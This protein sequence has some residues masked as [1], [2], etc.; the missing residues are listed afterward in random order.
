M[1]CSRPI[2]SSLPRDTF[3]PGSPCG[4]IFPRGGYLHLSYPGPGPEPHP[5][6]FFQGEGGFSSFLVSRDAGGQSY[7]WLGKEQG[8]LRA[9]IGFWRLWPN[10]P[11]LRVLTWSP[12][13]SSMAAPLPWQTAKMPISVCSDDPTGHWWIV[14]D[15]SLSHTHTH[16]TPQKAR[17]K[18][19][20]A[21][22]LT[23][24]SSST[25]LMYCG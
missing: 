13:H 11:G 19:R 5:Q 25:R 12:G 22:H 10:L 3:L 18:G 9:W 2:S 15:L 4:L 21:A 8:P 23:N 20:G 17:R 6:L 16:T 14:P 1:R 7:C 24:S